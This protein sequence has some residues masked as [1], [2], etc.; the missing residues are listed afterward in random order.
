MSHPMLSSESPAANALVEQ[1]LAFTGEQPA[2]Q[3]A[4]LR[5]RLERVLASQGPKAVACLLDRLATTGA[6]FAYYP[7]D[8]LARLIHYALAELAVTPGSALIDADHLTAARGRPVVLLSNHLS[9]SDANL[10]QILLMR[11][12]FSDLADRLTVIAGPKVYS[13]PM[14]RFSSLCFG[15]IKTPQSSAR[16]SEEAGLAAREG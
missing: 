11:A 4:V 15:T 7:P 9:Y 2:E 13:D 12:G 10:L 3:L 14:R 1:M 6:T 16:S 5:E 8:P